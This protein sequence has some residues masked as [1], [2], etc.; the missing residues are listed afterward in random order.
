[1]LP[2]FYSIKDLELR[3]SAFAA[4]KH[5]LKGQRRKYTGE[6]YI[7]H[8]GN[9]A[10][11]LRLVGADAILLAAAWCHDLL[12]DTDTTFP[13]LEQVLCREVAE[14]VYWVTNRSRPEG[15]NRAARKRIDH[16]HIG[17]ATIPAKT[18]KLADL[19]DNSRSI[20]TRDPKFAVVYLA[21]KKALLE[22][23]TEG[24]EALYRQATGIIEAAEGGAP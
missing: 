15:G 20:L 11:I 16:Q 9:V 14:L 21:E 19:I 17:I 7:V 8:P 3:A 4:Y 22:V 23:L 5:G 6:P 1:M 13:E 12:E 24:D 10:N 2:S 18:L